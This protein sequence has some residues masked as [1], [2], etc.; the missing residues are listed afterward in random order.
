MIINENELKSLIFK[1]VAGFPEELEGADFQI[2]GKQ[3]RRLRCFESS[4]FSLHVFFP[5]ARPPEFFLKSRQFKTNTMIPI[6]VN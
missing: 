6:D 1:C 4:D 2:H 5:K 3:Q